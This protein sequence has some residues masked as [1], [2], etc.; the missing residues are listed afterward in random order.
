MLNERKES[1]PGEV[2]LF[3]AR[4]PIFDRKNDVF[5]YELLYRSN[6]ENR[7]SIGDEEYAT[8]KVISN[9]LMIGLQKLTEGKRAFINFNHKLLI[10]NVPLLYSN[11]ML[12]VEII[13][14]VSPED[15]ILKAC[16]RIKNLGYP[17]IL[18]NFV[19]KESTAPF[20]EFADIIKINF[21]TTPRKD[22]LSILQMANNSIKFLASKVET[23]DEFDEAF[24]LGY[25]YF[26]GFYFQK[27]TL[28]QFSEMPGYKLNYLSILRMI[29]NPES[30]I[31][32]IEETIKRDVS[33][34]Y[35]LLRFINS[36]AHGF[37]VE[38]RSISHALLL[39]GKRELK[40]WLTLIV[41]SSLAKDKPSE[42]MKMAVIRARFCELIAQEYNL[43]YSP[44]DLF[45][46]G[47][48]SMSEA[49]LDRPLHHILD[50]LPL[51][52]HIKSVLLNE[53]GQAGDALQFVK[54]FEKAD[55]EATSRYVKKMEMN[56]EKLALLYLDAVEWAKFL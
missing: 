25:S 12:G 34:T 9:S 15:Y 26:Q 49:F 45:L 28:I 36:A 53:D 17:I 50:E 29:F 20:L 37:K 3:I 10:G 54:A 4:Q 39:L 31:S 38:I 11:Q 47:M 40:R 16:S 46:I 33:L 30:Q 6:M 43:A 35:K 41:M 32:E 19:L 55:W 14:T 7:A 5:A 51:E 22:R 23:K 27:P 2:G 1:R 24:H 21:Q 52:R 56:E 48:F 18:D 8:I 42:L 13:E 44:E